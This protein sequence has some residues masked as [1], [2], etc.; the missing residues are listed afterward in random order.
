MVNH[1]RN[2]MVRTRM[3]RLEY[4]LFL[5]LVVEILQRMRRRGSVQND[6]MVKGVSI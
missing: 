1:K 5:E 3:K 6:H 2:V 4:L